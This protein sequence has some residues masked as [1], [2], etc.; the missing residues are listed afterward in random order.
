M[1]ALVACGS[2]PSNLAVGSTLPPDLTLGLDLFATGLSN[3]VFLTAPMQD[4]RVFI[5]EQAGRIRVVR[6]GELQA[7][8]LLDIS[9]LVGSGGC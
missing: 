1:L 3:P 8:P 5:V 9:S 7:A 2:S 4:G 6:D